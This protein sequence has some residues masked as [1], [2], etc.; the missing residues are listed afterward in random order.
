[1]LR[2]THSVIEFQLSHKCGGCTSTVRRYKN[3][4]EI[5][6]V[7]ENDCDRTTQITDDFPNLNIDEYQS[8]NFLI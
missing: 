7:Y 5:F 3:D 4:E 8:L 6:W 2:Y 1:M